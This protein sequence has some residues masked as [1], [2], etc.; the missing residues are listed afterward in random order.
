MLYNESSET[1]AKNTES[2]T[3]KTEKK[4]KEVES[5]A[6]QLCQK[7]FR[8]RYFLKIIFITHKSNEK[9]ICMNCK[10]MLII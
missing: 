8:G 5:K 1:K 4:V 2:L 9:E 7:P 6:E 10:E 3:T